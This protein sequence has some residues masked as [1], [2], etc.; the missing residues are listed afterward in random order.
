MKT[1]LLFFTLLIGF[2]SQVYSKDFVHPGILM[3]TSDLERMKSQVEAGEEPWFSTYELLKT[4]NSASY[5]YSVVGSPSVTTM[6]NHSAFINDANAAFHNALMWYITGDERHAQKSVEIFNAYANITRIEDQFALN[7]GRGP[8]KMCEAAEIIRST[9]SG[10]SQNDIDRFKAMLVYPGWSGT[11]APTEAMASKDVTFYWNIYQ[12][13]P[14]R[15]GNQGLFAYRSLM[16]M[17][18]FLDNEI[19]YDRALRYLQGLP[20]REDDLPYPSGPP[21]LSS[22]KT[23]GSNIYY[24]EYSQLSRS[25][26]IEDYGY[27]EV[28]SNYIYENGQCQESSRDQAHPLAGIVIINTMCEMAWNQG[29]NLYG[30]LDNRPLL[31]MEHYFRYNLTWDHSYPDQLTP[32]EPTVEN[33][34]FIQRSDR[35]GRWYSLKINPYV[36][37]NLEPENFER[38]NFNENPIYELILGHYKDRMLLPSEDYKW[39]K[40]GQDVLLASKGVEDGSGV[41]D[42]TGYGGLLFHRV[43]PGDPIEGYDTLGLPIYKMNEVPTLIEAENFDHFSLKG[44]GY[45]YHDESANN[46]GAAYRTGED[47]DIEVC[48]EG[49]YNLAKLENGEWLTYTISVPSTGLY[50]IS[51]NYASANANGKIKLSVDSIDITDEISIPFGGDNS[52]SLTDWN[53]YTLVSDIILKQGVHALKVSIAGNSEAFVLNSF[54]ITVGSEFSCE[55]G[56]EASSVPSFITKGVNF[57][58]YEGTWDSLPDFTQLTADEVGINDSITLIEGWSADNF[59]AVYSGYIELPIDGSYTFY[60][61]SDEG[62]RLYVDGT[63]L[64][65][66]NGIHI[67]AEASGSV[68]LDEG[69]HEIKVEYFE[70]TGDEGLSV[71]YDGPGI[72]KRNLEG[73]YAIGPCE[74]A[75]VELPEDAVPGIGYYYYEGTWSALP[76]FDDEEILGIGVTSSVNLNMAEVADYFGVVF[77]GYISVPEDGDYTFYTTSDD[78]SSL[79]IDGL[80]VIN[81]ESVGVTVSGDLCLAAGWHE[82]EIHYCE[83]SGGNTLSVQWEGDNFS[84][85]TITGYYTD[86][87][88]PVKQDQFLT[89]NDLTRYLGEEDFDAAYA[90][91]GLPPTYTSYNTEVATV[92]D[93][94]IHLVGAGKAQIRAYQLGNI[95]YNGAYKITDTLIVIAPESQTIT[96]SDL[97]KYIGDADFSPAVASSGLPVSYESFNTSVAMVVDDKIRIIGE[98]ATYMRALQEGD[99]MYEPA[100]KVLF[101]LTVLDGSA[102]LEELE[103]DKVILFPNPADDELTIEVSDSEEVQVSII[104]MLGE[105]VMDDVTFHNNITLNVE[106][107]ESGYFVVA[108]YVDG[109]TLNYK[110]LKK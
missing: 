78:R 21:V 23:D 18:I 5:N 91:S 51:I 110:L 2:I 31:G 101:K 103:A 35:T 48:S 26:T 70:K 75:A 59:A 7:N 6:E 61:S 11:E 27:N 10:W 82:I 87:T 45:T 55:D 53:D 92:V 39:L 102:L 66:N 104:N 22:S 68:C 44:E 15:H 43:S 47:V 80:R 108:V 62:A 50:N 37:N 100:D 73:L 52:T 8:W 32:W 79:Y 49:G 107:L 90:S 83:F 17:A 3:K 93:G 99:Q 60:T 85:Q 67:D 72:S 19:M 12:G 28:M 109:V 105:V 96:V 34:E 98:G 95:F 1:R 97:T 29:D 30:H 84:K 38:G 56:W 64:V 42:F 65:D 16:A 4:Q 63:L 20:H 69:Y 13:D 94:K 41:S 76:D 86:V 71:F 57:S 40:R 81:N 89:F 74:N 106:A 14:A 58:Y 46:S 77:K 33:G 24:D 36:A 88:I 25:S 9:Y 54:E